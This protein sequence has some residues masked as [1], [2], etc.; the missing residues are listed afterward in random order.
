[1]SGVL[2]SRFLLRLRAGYD[3]GPNQPKTGHAIGKEDIGNPAGA[4]SVPSDSPPCPIPLH[5][6]IFPH[7]MNGNPPASKSWPRPA[8]EGFGKQT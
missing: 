4:S 7:A 3:S 1:M 2:F 8:T 6:L 5:A